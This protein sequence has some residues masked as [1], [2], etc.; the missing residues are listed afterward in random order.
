M[1]TP[2]TE[3]QTIIDSQARV[4]VVRAV[5]GSGKTWLVADLIKK[6]LAHWQPNHGGIAA[7]SFT[8]VGGEEIRRAVGY[9]LHHPHFVAQ[10][11]HSFLGLLCVHF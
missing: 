9:E 5:P 10:L 8:R 4:R 1:S 3:Q 7:L 11:T 6:E 2:T